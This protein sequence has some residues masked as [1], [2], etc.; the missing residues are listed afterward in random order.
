MLEA[1]YILLAEDNDDDT[2]FARRCF[3]AA[4]IQLE[5]KRCSNGVEITTELKGCGAHLPLAVML[6]LKMPFMDGFD[7][8][9][10][11]REQPALAHLPV[12]ILSS[13]GLEEDRK[14]AKALGCS[15]FLVK[16]SSLGDL[17]LL[18]KKLVERLLATAS[19]QARQAGLSAAS[20]AVSAG[21]VLPSH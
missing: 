10:W 12:V 16:P 9:K 5:L 1:P 14:R 4:G 13:S 6:D 17:E 7:T 3:A 2:Y 15:E 19:S 8:L 18:L 20:P 11:I 21:T